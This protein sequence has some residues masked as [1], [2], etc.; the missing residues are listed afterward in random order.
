MSAYNYDEY[1]KDDG[2]SPELAGDYQDDDAVYVDRLVTGTATPV[3]P[4]PTVMVDL[5]HAAL[6]PR[7]RLI[8]GSRSWTNSAMDATDTS[9]IEQVLPFDPNRK[10]LNLFASTV[11]IFNAAGSNV[12]QGILIADAKDKLA[13]ISDYLAH[14]YSPGSI[15]GFLLLPNISLSIDD[16]TGPLWVR[17]LPDTS[18]SYTGVRLSWMGITQ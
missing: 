17:P 11:P 5:N 12:T 1:L 9:F 3:I 14:T 13:Y 10:H 7:G 15:Q 18:G 8:T 16:Y 6:L 4:P 2:K